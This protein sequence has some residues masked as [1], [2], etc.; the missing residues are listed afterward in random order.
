MRRSLRPS[1]K[2]VSFYRDFRKTREFVSFFFFLRYISPWQTWH[3]FSI[4][5]L[6]TAGARPL[7]FSSR[8]TVRWNKTG[9]RNERNV[10]RNLHPFLRFT[11]RFAKQFRRCIFL[12]FFFLMQT[13]LNLKWKLSKRNRANVYRAAFKIRPNGLNWCDFG[14][15][16]PIIAVAS[17]SAEVMISG[18]GWSVSCAGERPLS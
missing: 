9:K 14:K 17:R 16:G 15:W 11:I 18:E 4:T 13:I 12:F 6:I 7:H 5:E 3:C 1:R 10:S 8:K 2:C